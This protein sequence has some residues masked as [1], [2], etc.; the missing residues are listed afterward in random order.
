M[1]P[2]LSFI[3]T[4]SLYFVSVGV[5]QTIYI[6]D[7][8][9][10]S[11]VA[12]SIRILNDRIQMLGYNTWPGGFTKGIYAFVGGVYDGSTY[13]WMVPYSADRVIR[14]DPSN[15]AMTGYNS[16]PAG[17]TKG[18]NAFWGGVYDGTYLWMVPYS[19]DRVIRL[20]PS[21]GV[22]TRYSSW[23]A[24]FTKAAQAFSGG[25]YDGRF[26]WIIPYD[27]DRFIRLDTLTGTMKGYNNW[28]V[29]FAK[30]SNTFSG[31]VYAANSIWA[32]P[33]NADRIMRL[34]APVRTISNS[35]PHHT[36]TMTDSIK[37]IVR[38]VSISKNVRVSKN[39]LSPTQV[40]SYSYFSHSHSETLVRSFRHQTLSY[41]AD[42]KPTWTIS[43]SLRRLSRTYSPTTTPTVN[44]AL[45]YFQTNS[46]DRVETISPS[47]TRHKLRTPSRETY[48]PSSIQDVTY[49]NTSSVTPSVTKT[50]IS[51]LL[52]LTKPVTRTTSIIRSRNVKRIGS[53]TPSITFPA[54]FVE[55]LATSELRL[56]G[57]E[58]LDAQSIPRPFIELRLHMSRW[59]WNLSGSEFVLRYLEC[60]DADYLRVREEIARTST[61]TLLLSNLVLRLEMG[62]CS[63]FNVN[64]DIVVQFRRDLR[65]A[66][67][68]SDVNPPPTWLSSSPT[69]FIISAS[70][71]L[72][73]RALL[74]T[75][76][77]LTT[78]EVAASFSAASPNGMVVVQTMT[79]VG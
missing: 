62:G 65:E 63:D 2:P 55:V 69:S 35:N 64:H 45:T 68:G 47:T 4:W 70:K 48:S 79:L 21:N 76:T 54:T 71:A 38:T 15:G 52:L 42:I 23:P 8:T 24:G 25:V 26:I 10:F 57:D 36:A 66:I 58:L 60:E 28:P 44:V 56:A 34:R 9:G 53:V 5:V 39:T 11:G 14:F 27:A 49:G 6:Q 17:F 19:A 12:T 77:V 72:P 78:T 29:G 46:I 20:D 40:L 30:G 13:I 59:R 16:W 74:V 3:L 32:M 33:T 73:T 1:P 37:S 75:T 31:G 61:V 18:I 7:G 41:S 22:M 67:E 51:T 43:T 50:N